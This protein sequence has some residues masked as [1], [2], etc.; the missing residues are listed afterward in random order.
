V[1][2]EKIWS[3]THQRLS[4]SKVS[5]LFHSH[6]CLPFF[7][8]ILILVTKYGLKLGYFSFTGT[9]TDAA[10]QKGVQQESKWKGAIQIQICLLS[11]T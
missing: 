1:G 9:I 11:A 2:L 4:L 8:K 5:P 3:K 10:A 6:F 7:K